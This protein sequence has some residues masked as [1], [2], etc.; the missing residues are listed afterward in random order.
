MA[1]VQFNK[2][3]QS[4][5]HNMCLDTGCTMTLIDRD[6]LNKVAPEAIIKK[7]TFPVSIRNIGPG[8]HSLVNYTTI[9]LYLPRNNQHTAAITR[10]VHVVDRPKAQMLIGMDIL[11]RESITIDTGN[12][13][14]TIGSCNDIVIPFEVTPQVRN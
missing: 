4:Q 12:K 14:A 5:V 11:V 3:P 8:K 7:L 2:N 10:K 1:N 9:N 13:Q 6:F